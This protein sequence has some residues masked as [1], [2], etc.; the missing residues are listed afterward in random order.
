MHR[1]EACEITLRKSP[2]FPF[3]TMPSKKAMKAAAPTPALK[4]MK[5]MKK[6]KK[7]ASPVPPMKAMKAMKGM[8]ARPSFVFKL[9]KSF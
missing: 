6:N 2:P 8:K 4:G 7:A 9:T 5:A 1:D 3:T